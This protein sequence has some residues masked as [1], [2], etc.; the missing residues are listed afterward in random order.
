MINALM[1]YFTLHHEVTQKCAL[2]R[3]FWCKCKLRSNTFIYS[4]KKLL[5]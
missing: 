4:Q 1:S 3:L 5:L 2:I